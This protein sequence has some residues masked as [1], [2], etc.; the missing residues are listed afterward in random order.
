MFCSLWFEYRR[1]DMCFDT[2]L[3]LTVLAFLARVIA[4]HDTALRS[5]DWRRVS[6]ATV[7]V[8]ALCAKFTKSG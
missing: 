1:T 2:I 5:G 8:C 6:P 7:G 3:V 4:Q